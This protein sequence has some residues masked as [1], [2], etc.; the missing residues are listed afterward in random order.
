MPL[1]QVY[2]PRRLT[3][4]HT[5][6][7]KGKNRQ[8]K[9]LQWSDLDLLRVPEGAIVTL[10]HNRQT[11]FTAKTT[12]DHPLST[13][14]QNLGKNSAR[15]ACA[16]TPHHNKK[17]MTADMRGGVQG[18]H[19]EQCYQTGMLMRL[20]HNRIPAMTEV[21]IV[22]QTKHGPI[23]AG[24]ADLEVEHEY[25]FELKVSAYSAKDTVQLQ[26]YIHALRSQGRTVNGAAVICFTNH[27]NWVPVPM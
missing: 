23:P 9:R 8:W 26:R 19:T 10:C 7:K 25:L 12:K 4:P 13:T 24:R 21:P 1:Q 5:H 17:Y 22:F 18:G 27:V 16:T 14:L 20:Y 2:M 3:P 11:K 15:C 6:A